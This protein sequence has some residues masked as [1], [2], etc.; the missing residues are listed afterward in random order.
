MLLS[1]D[2]LSGMN[3][4]AGACVWRCCCQEKVICPSVLQMAKGVSLRAAADQASRTLQNA[5]QRVVGTECLIQRSTTR[6][7][8]Y[9]RLR[10]K[11]PS[12]LI[13][14]IHILSCC[15]LSL[16]LAAR[17][18]YP[19][20]GSDEAQS[21]PLMLVSPCRLGLCA[22]RDGH[23]AAE[24][25]APC[26]QHRASRID[27]EPEWE[28]TAGR[29]RPGRQRRDRCPAAAGKASK[30]R[31]EQVQCHSRNATSGLPPVP[32]SKGCIAPRI[33][34]RI[35]TLVIA[36]MVHLRSTE[37]G[38]LHRQCCPSGLALD[39]HPAVEK[40]SP[41]GLSTLMQFPFDHRRSNRQGSSKAGGGK[42]KKKNTAAAS[43]YKLLA[44]LLP[45]VGR[46]IVL[47]FALA[48]LRTSISIRLARVQVSQCCAM[49]CNRI[50]PLKAQQPEL[51]PD[52][53]H[54]GF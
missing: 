52:F 24:C 44:F 4:S 14:L 54:S 34:I 20:Y 25:S 36:L 30:A 27:K 41:G 1:A 42:G 45:L 21:C 53:C 17:Q 51:P 35:R 26:F 2:K 37:V 3:S 32:C 33:M 13:S 49:P 43:V 40:C 19:R 39:I 8:S 50:S 16:L 29:C 11:L 48:V 10:R 46:K 6:S 28:A 5:M 15:Y 31:Q 47:L 23:A 38:Q 12:H 22:I 9:R 18:H 7:R